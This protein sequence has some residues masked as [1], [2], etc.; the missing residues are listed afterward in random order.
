MLFFHPQICAD[1]MWSN[2]MK[3]SEIRWIPQN[4][5]LR[6]QINFR[7]NYPS[8]MTD[9]IKI[10][11][12]FENPIFINYFILSYNINTNVR[13]AEQH[14]FSIMLITLR[15]KEFETIFN[16]RNSNMFKKRTTNHFLPT[17][18]YAWWIVLTPKICCRKKKVFK[19]YTIASKKKETTI[20]LNDAEQKNKIWINK[21][22]WIAGNM[23]FSILYTDS[24]N[25][26]EQKILSLNE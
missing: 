11:I 24:H 15:K 1:T 23:C 18:F 26:Q 20:L 13:I 7:Y 12:G 6:C 5:G 4:R 3:N 16:K 17:A 19:N 9:E 10:K 25:I 22:V 2:E 21:N 8:S 14:C